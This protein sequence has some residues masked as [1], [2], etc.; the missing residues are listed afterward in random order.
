[1]SEQGRIIAKSGLNFRKVPGGDRISLL[2]FG[3]VV[4]IRGETAGWLEAEFDGQ[5]G[6]VFARY[7]ARE[8]Q[9]EPA[10]GPGFRFEGRDALAPDGTVFAKK[11]RRGVFNY[12]E[13][14]IGDFV[15]AQSQLFQALSPSLGEFGAAS[16]VPPRQ[17]GRSG[18]LP[19]IIAARAADGL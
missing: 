3:S 8:Q 18:R 4:T 7:V 16:V 17:C 19:T 6:Y 10:G 11:F 1:M 15:S 12:G 2:P 13:T 14:S 9:A 5:V